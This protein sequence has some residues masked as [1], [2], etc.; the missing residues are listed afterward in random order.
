MTSYQRAEAEKTLC[1]LFFFQVE[2]L[3]SLVGVSKV[4]AKN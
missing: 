1:A 4:A 3:I 2:I